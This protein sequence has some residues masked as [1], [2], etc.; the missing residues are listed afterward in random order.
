M[1]S[2]NR[3]PG[4]LQTV[5]IGLVDLGTM[6]VVTDSDLFD[7]NDR[8]HEQ[9]LVVNLTYSCKLVTGTTLGVALLLPDH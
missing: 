9:T 6:A 5:V 2:S 3:S 4:C 8:F 1:T 7:T